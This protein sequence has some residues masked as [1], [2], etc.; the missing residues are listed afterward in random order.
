MTDPY[1]RFPHLHGD[2]V[3]F[4][5]ADDVWLAPIDGGRAWR[6]TDE[7]SPANN[8]RFSPDGTHIAWAAQRGQGREVFVAAIDGGP[9]SQLTFWGHATTTVAGWTGDGRVLVSSA[10][11]EPVLRDVWLKAIDLEGAIERL[12]YGPASALARGD[13]G[14]IVV[15]SAWNREPAHWKRY[16]GG[17]APQI[18]IDRGGTGDFERLLPEITAGL[19]WPTWLEGRVAF[20]SDH[21]GVGNLY[22]VAPDGTDLRKHTHH[23]AD[24]GYVRNISGDGRRIIYHALGDVHVMENLDAEPHRV[25]IRLGG[26]LSARDVR[27]LVAD[28]ELTSARPTHDGAGAVVE[29]RGQVCYVTVREGPARALGAAAG[30]R[31]RDA[32]PLGRTNLAVFVTDADGEDALDVV[33]LDG[34]TEPRR[35]AG[36]QLGRVLSLQGSPVGNRVAAVSHDGRVLVIDVESGHID[37]VGLGSRGEPTGLAFSPDGRWLAWSQPIGWQRS[38]LHLADLE[39]DAGSRQDTAVTSARFADFSPAFSPDGQYLCFLSNRTFD[40]VYDRIVFQMGFP[41]GTRPYLI[42]LLSETPAPFGPSVDGWP[43]RQP[44]V[45]DRP[46]EPSAAAPAPAPVPGPPPAVHIDL[47]GFEERLVALPVPAGDYD[48]LTTVDGGLLWLHAPVHGVLGAGR[49]KPDDPAPKAAL[50][51]FDLDGRRLEV[52]NEHV[53]G[54]EPT[55][56]GLHVLVREDQKLL[57]LPADRKLPVDDPARVEVDLSRIHLRLDPV[58]EWTQMF[59]EAVRLMRDHY[60]RE[61]MGGI[62]W[63]AVA[64]RYRPLVERLAGRDDLIDVLWETY[65][66]LGTSHAYVMAPPTPP[67]PEETQ[68]LLGADVLP[69][70]DGTWRI[71]RILPGESSDPTARSPLRAAGVGARDGDAIVEVSGQPVEPRCGPA[72][73]LVGTAGKPTELTLQPADGDSPRRRVVVVPLADEEPLRYQAWVADRREYVR[74]RAD[75]RVGYL[76][77]PDMM[78][79]G[80]AQL[81]RDLSLA[82]SCDGIVVDVRFN[83]GGHV[84]QLVIERLGRRVHAY[85][86]GRHAGSDTYPDSAPRGPLV[87]VANQWSGSD[88]DIVNAMAQEMGIG[89][90]IGVRTWGG[91]VGIDNRFK[92]V[93]GTDVTQPRYATW[94]QNRGWSVENHGVD[95]DIE[96]PMTPADHATGRDPQLD[97]AV[98][99]VLARLEEHPASV[100]P[101]IPPLP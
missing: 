6:L 80:W 21:E 48:H 24:Q 10:G 14:T 62:D 9:V 69:D 86:I 32:Q 73:A 93:D 67:P 98:D 83:R 12:A 59:D 90:V 74:R 3:T 43:L 18:W 25:P 45:D 101:E 40:P 13:D 1:L 61:D 76:H 71:T 26:T 94:I 99:E 72:A 27:A 52:L 36:E 100:P 4:V 17:T 7:H 78:G 50:E 38:Q 55:L 49:A 70:S 37:Q 29:M 87:F 2:L 42:P 96:V 57:A 53:D 11:G 85:Q 75:G 46:P 30:V 97:R 23:N 54:Y 92:L 16:R 20:V 39:A 19:A 82:T 68:G 15:G 47:E 58:A 89:P 81:H 8:P 91:V 51:R 79:L 28:E 5:A 95:P 60:W 56:D 88:G 66:E 63:D 22:S 65:A 77:V 31:A 41:T 34:S 33:A 84:S 35:L 44:G 64:R